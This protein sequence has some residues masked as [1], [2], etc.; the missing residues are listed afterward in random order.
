[1]LNFL[2]VH[3]ATRMYWQARDWDATLALVQNTYDE[4]GD[5]ADRVL[6][7][8]LKS[9]FGIIRGDSTESTIDPWQDLGLES[10]SPETASTREML[11]GMAELVGGDLEVAYER[12]VAAAEQQPDDVY[13]L[14]VAM[15]A[16]LWLR[17]RDKATTALGRLEEYPATGRVGQ[18][19]RTWARAGF[20]ALE[21]RVDEAV[22]GFADADARFD[23]VSAQLPRAE[24][25]LDAVI[26]LPDRPELRPAAERARETFQQVGARPYL[27]RL[28]QA[29]AI[30]ESVA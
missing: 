11:H 15:R 7:L 13:A 3:F 25:A 12:F 27:D 20:A 19:F 21:G 8:S 5:D 1:M 28:E 18:A 10:D 6:L 9:F 17:D 29:L 26:L 4:A 22:A 30:A 24:A 14:G 23:E 2:V 16:A